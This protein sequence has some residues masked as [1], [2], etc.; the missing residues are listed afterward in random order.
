MARRRRHH[1][2]VNAP[3]GRANG[4]LSRA[5]EMREFAPILVRRLRDAAIE[6]VRHAEWGS[7]LG[8]LYLAAKKSSPHNTLRESDGQSSPINIIEPS[9]RRYRT[10]DRG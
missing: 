7:E 2:S 6:S 8:R 3:T 1:R 5:G 10:P 9:Q 4:R